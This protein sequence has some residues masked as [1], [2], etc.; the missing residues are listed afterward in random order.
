MKKTSVNLVPNIVN[1]SPDYYCTWQTQLYATCDGKPAGQRAAIG[2]KAMFLK[3]KPYGWA[4]FYEKARGD[5]FF[6]MDDSWDVPLSGDKAY[7]GCL[8]LDAEK[9]PE[10]VNGA[11]NNTEALKKLADRVK[12]LGWKGLGGWVCAQ[13]SVMAEGHENSE[14]YWIKRLT[15]AENAGFSYWKVDWGAKA[16]IPEFRRMIT[17]LGRKYAPSLVIEHALTKEIIP[18][19]DVFRTYDVPAIMSVPLTMAKIK[20]FCDVEKPDIGF[21]SLIN[22]EDEVY[23]AAAGGFIMGIMRHP[24][25][26]EFVNGKKDMSFP[27]AHGRNLKTKMY[28]IIRAVRWHR[29]A[30][31]FA[32]GTTE[33]LIDEN[34][35]VDTW[36]FENA[37][38]EI[39][40]WWLVEP[41]FSPDIKD[42]VVTKTAPARI[43]RNCK[44]PIVS[45]VEKDGNV[46]YVIASKNPN[47]VFSVATLGRTYGRAYEIPK[48]NVTLDIENSDIVGVFGEYENLILETKIKAKTVLMQDMAGEEAF[49]ITDYITFEEE[50]IIVPGSLISKIGTSAQPE[51]DTSEPGCIIKIAED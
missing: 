28:E 7:C 4:Y 11:K 8:E 39:E 50:K 5:L 6:V 36:N 14:E 48:C 18:H 35:L 45:A 3:E 27:D 9:F 20:A 26:G 10:F 15:E 46:P 1:P 17:D 29:I 41:V 30:P 34:Y 21:S 42:G 2:E 25:S 51:N 47:G 37:E 31:A 12:S 33:I 13:E 32:V 23:L 16:R 24:Y 43:S 49:D 40:A 44:L 38:D 19:C 22:C